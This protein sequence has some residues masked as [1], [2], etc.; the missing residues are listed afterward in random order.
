MGGGRKEKGKK[1]KEEK[2]KK[3]TELFLIDHKFLR[4]G[5]IAVLVPWSLRQ[6]KQP[7][8]CLVYYRGSIAVTDGWIEYMCRWM[9][10]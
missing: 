10:M 8:Q 7:V 4:T 6:P 2:E 1:G 3:N 9:Y 5:T